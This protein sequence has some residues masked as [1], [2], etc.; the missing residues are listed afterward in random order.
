MKNFC[1]A[2]AQQN[3]IVGDIEGNL[4]LAKKNIIEAEEANADIILFSEL[5]L[6]GYPTE[7]LVLKPSFLNKCSK[8]INDIV[9]F[10]SK[11]N[12]AIIVG[13][14]DC[15]AQKVYNAVYF[16]AQGHI[17]A[18]S[19]KRDLP[20]YAEFDEKRI[21]SAGDNSQIVEYKGINIALPICEDVW[22]MPQI[23]KGECDIILVANA[24]PHRINKTEKRLKLISNL[25]KKLECCVIYVNQVGG[26]DEMVFDGASF[27]C[28]VQGDVICKLPQFQTHIE[29]LNISDNC[30]A[31]AIWYKD[32]EA[33]YN[34]CILAVRDYVYKNGF[35]K[36]ILGL[37]GGLDSALCAAMVCDAIGKDNLNCFMLPYVYTSQHSLDDAKKCAN[38]LGCT[39]L[40]LNI[41]K[42]VEAF[43]SILESAFDTNNRNLWF[44]NLQSRTRGT[45]LMALSNKLNALLITTGNKSEL[46]TG[47][48]TIYGDMSGGFNP[49]KDIYKT[50][51]YDLANW[52][53]N[54]FSATFL[55][56]KGKIIPQ[57]IIEKPA[58]AELR[59][60]QKDEDSLAPYN[61]LDVILY[62]LIEND[63][64]VEQIIKK[65]YDKDLVKKIE[66]LVY[67]AEY[68]RFQAAPGVR[69]GAKNFGTDRRYPI[70]N[71]YRDN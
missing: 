11:L 62:E 5:F 37:S 45:I 32:L 41:S 50:R 13:A 22:N 3:P 46:A 44:E 55:G 49:L 29:Y 4:A 1:I 56:K 59:E 70:T 26:Q 58:S 52:R 23:T 66:N 8:A 7:D 35:T 65:G 67:L 53:N 61:I 38:L 33:D 68:K 17:V 34:A 54:N 12:I 57:S 16:I 15:I 47:Y 18:K 42:A 31:Q 20:N 25:A 40:E 64:S 30:G 36:C 27:A 28:N 60:G 24:S 2:M 48:A 9:E 21:F 10:S 43:L 14:P 51:V 19:H 39:Y 6:C 63:A 69:L 71:K